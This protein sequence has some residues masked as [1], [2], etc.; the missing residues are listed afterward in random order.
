MGKSYKRPGGN[1]MGK[2]ILIIKRD[3]EYSNSQGSKGIF[4]E[5]KKGD[6]LRVKKTQ[7]VDFLEN[8]SSIS[9]EF[10]EILKINK[11]V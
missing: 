8:G 9:V 2:E 5:F 1:A 11:Q 4:R 7:K 6:R 3:C 10:A